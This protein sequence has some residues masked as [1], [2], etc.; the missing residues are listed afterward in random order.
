MR[1]LSIMRRKATTDSEGVRLLALFAMTVPLWGQAQADAIRSAMEASLQKQRESVR[2]QVAG[3]V[4][5]AGS[6]SS[7][8]FTVA[9]PRPIQLLRADCDPLPKSRVEE[10][11][12]GAATQEGVKPELIRGVMAQESGFKPCAVSVSGAQGLMQLMPGTAGDLGVKDPF[13]PQQNVAAGTRFLKQLLERYNGDVSLA[14]S[15]Y[16]AGPTTV[17]KAGGVPSIAETQ[18]YVKD[19]VKRLSWIP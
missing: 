10:L 19:I 12:A 18:N 13:D 11:I 8:F 6:Q 15:A 16:N 4:P 14:L 17:D 1:V 7:N 2:A 3:A 9:W 5:M